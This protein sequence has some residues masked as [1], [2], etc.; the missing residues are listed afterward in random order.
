M[1]SL[2]DPYPTKGTTMWVSAKGQ[3]TMPKHIR[4]AAGVRADR[5]ERLAA[6]AA[7]VRQSLGPDFRQLG[8]AG[9][10]Y[11]PVIGQTRHV[12]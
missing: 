5:R 4:I 1:L 2:S 7:R 10:P 3:V 6:A 11:E 8:A 9:S 12:L